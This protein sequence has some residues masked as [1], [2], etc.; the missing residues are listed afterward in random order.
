MSLASVQQ[1]L[2]NANKVTE[3][4]IR[5]FLTICRIKYLRAK[6]EPGEFNTPYLLTR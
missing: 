4:Q 2:D 1:V 5:T 3:A 6:I